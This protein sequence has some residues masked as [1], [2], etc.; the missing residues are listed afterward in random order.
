MATVN[1]DNIEP[2]SKTYKSEKKEKRERK[3]IDPVIKKDKIVA[4]KKPL[5]KR[6]WDLFIGQDPK[7]LRDYFIKDVLIPEMLDI[8]G[9]GFDSVLDNIGMRFGSG[10]A[11]KRTGYGGYS[12]G[13]VSY[14][15]L[16]KKSYENA[17]RNRPTR[18]DRNDRDE[19]QNDKVDYRNVVLQYREDAENVIDH[20][21]ERIEDTGSISVAEFFDMLELPSKFTDNDWGW[22]NA[23]DIGLKRV[24]GGWLIDVREAIHLD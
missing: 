14:S 15:G 23:R 17:R 4:T 6:L 12:N 11:R 9:M 5:G 18:R 7:D 3:K 16:F 8:A 2:N 10:P 21:I 19:Y 1:L 13:K 24:H 22:E 20:M